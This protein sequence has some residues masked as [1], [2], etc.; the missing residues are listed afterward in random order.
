MSVV[1]SCEVCGCGLE[2]EYIPGV[3]LSSSANIDGFPICD[4]CMI[5]HCVS[6]SCLGCERGRYPDC[7]FLEI[8]ADYMGE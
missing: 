6:T 2:W 7:R 1:K 8:K 4:S 5:E 3:R